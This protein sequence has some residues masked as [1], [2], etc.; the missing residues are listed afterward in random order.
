MKDIVKQKEYIDRETGE[1]ETFE[2][3]SRQGDFN[4]EKIWIGHI[5]D[6]LDLIGNQK[7][8]VILHIMSKRN[9]TTNE[10]GGTQREIAKDT[11]VS[12]KTVNLT[13]KALREANFLQ[14]VRIGTYLINPDFIFKGQKGNRMR[15]ILEYNN[16][17]DK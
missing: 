9:K 3:M 2:V 14:P 1:V 13:I 10:F 15:V 4:F 6:T 17:G 11:G 7:I 5:V 8:T 16:I 12:L